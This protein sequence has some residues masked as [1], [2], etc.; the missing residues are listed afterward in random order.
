MPFPLFD[1]NPTSRVPWLTILLILVN[2]GVTIWTQ[3]LSPKQQFDLVCERGMVPERLTQI[4]SGKPVDIQ[5]P[6]DGRV[7]K[8]RVETDRGSVYSAMIT[9][10]FLHGGWLHLIMNMWMLW[11]FGNNVEDRLG[12][13]VFAAF[14]LMGGVIATYCH[15]AIDPSST[16]P[17][18]GASGAVWALLGGYA[19]TYPRAKVF[20]LVFVGIPLLL[21]VPAVLVIGLYFVIDLISGLAQLQGGIG[22]QIAHWAHVGGCVA[23]VVLMPLLA[24]GAPP[25]DADWRT[26]AGAMLD[27]DAQPINRLQESPPDRSEALAQA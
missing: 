18:I 8:T 21:N 17:M 9:T 12:H 6:F 25:P 16:T 10:L 3:G 15:W 22:E 11:I 4:G 14:Y 27:P 2:V 19:V 23:G 5:K 1:R 20:C 26:E 7:F 24:I 13:L